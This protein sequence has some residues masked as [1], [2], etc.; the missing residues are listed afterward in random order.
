MLHDLGHDQDTPDHPNEHIAALFDGAIQFAR[1]ACDA[2]VAG[3]DDD[4]TRRVLW[5][6]AVLED[7]ADRI[8]WGTGSLGRQM[9][10]ILRYL[11]VRL[12]DDAVTPE[13][14]EAFIADLATVYGLWSVVG[15]RA[16]SRR[17]AA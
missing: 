13:G 1:E 11:A 7:L 15:G 17:A 6:R 8:S 5:L 9:A 4:V 14:L 2:R 10:A 16:T 12:R 3:S